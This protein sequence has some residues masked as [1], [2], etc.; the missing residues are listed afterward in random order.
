MKKI[1]VAI[2][3]SDNA[4]RA[5]LEAKRLGEALNAKVE[6]VNIIEYVV[7]KSYATVQYHPIP[8][9]KD[10][11]EEGEKILKEASEMFYDF[12]GEV[13]AK[14][15][16]GDPAEVIIEKAEKEDYDFIIM[17]SRGLGTFSRAILGSVSNKVINHV[18]TNVL[19]VR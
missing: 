10:A 13:S 19:V 11:K 8:T 14:L 9:N 15:E 5:L 12:K 6:I 3:G 2:D 7:L 16:K 1:L 4:K 18:N 17:G